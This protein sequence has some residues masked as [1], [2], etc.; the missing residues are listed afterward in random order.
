MLLA[1]YGD[2]Y[3]DMVSVN[4]LPKHV[5]EALMAIED[6]RFYHHFGIDLMGI[7]RALWVNYHSGGVVQGGST[8]TQQLGKNILQAHKMYG[9][10]DRSIKR[11]IQETI[12]ALLLEAKLS[13]DQSKK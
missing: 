4:D 13:K 7:A 11:K 3:G 12:L 10:Q 9:Y 6:K 8:I 1:T 5:P 2:V